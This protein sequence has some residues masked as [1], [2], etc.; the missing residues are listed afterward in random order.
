MKQFL[1]LCFSVI[2]VSLSFGQSEFF[3]TE[4]QWDE[5]EF[6]QS[7][8]LQH[9]IKSIEVKT[10]HNG[11]ETRDEVAKGATYEYDEKGRMVQMVETQYDD[12]SKIHDFLYSDRGVL[13]WLDVTDKTWNKTYRSGYRFTGNQNVFQVKSYELLR[14]DERMLLDTRQYVYSKDSL[15]K[16]I[17]FK[18]GLN[19]V[20]RH[21]YD[22][23]PERRVVQERFLVGKENMWAKT[24]S[25]E[26]DDSGNI[27]RILVEEQGKEGKESHEYRYQY[28]PQDKPVLVEWLDNAQPKGKVA[29]TYDEA[30]KLLRMKRE[31]QTLGKDAAQLV[32]V[33]EYE[34]FAAAK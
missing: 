33:F 29:Y 32:Q 10:Y 25:Y 13:K 18:E 1:T 8:L 19:T 34:S 21:E 16:A 27:T 24:V 6:E 3:Q 12:T 2:C 4:F 31:V 26:Y 20:R 11:G 23:D 15:L 9:Q 17:I 28:N 22:H 30:G 5:P 14:N 7:F